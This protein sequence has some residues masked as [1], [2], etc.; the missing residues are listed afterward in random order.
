MRTVDTA[1]LGRLAEMVGAHRVAH[2]VRVAIDGPDAAGKTTLADRLAEAVRAAGRPALR[3]SI[4]DFHR[5]GRQIADA[6][7]DR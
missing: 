5:G 1:L 7:H 3:V 4:D 2:T 6:A